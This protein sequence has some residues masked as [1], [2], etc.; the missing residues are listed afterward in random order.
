MDNVYSNHER[1]FA[2]LNNWRPIWENIARY[3]VP[4]KIG[5]TRGSI[6]AQIF[7]ELYDSTAIHANEILAASMH[8]V[9]TNQVNRWFNLKTNNEALNKNPEVMVWLEMVADV[10]FIHYY[11]SNFN[12]EINGVYVDL[13]AFGT[14]A[15]FFEE[16]QKPDGGPEFT[17]TTLP[18]GS[19]AIGEDDDGSVNVLYREFKLSTLAAL[20]K[21]G[22]QVSEKVGKAA[23]EKPEEMLIFCHA[24]FPDPGREAK[25]PYV[26]VYLEKETKKLLE[27]GGYYEFPYLVPRWAK[28][29]GEKYGRG[30]GITALPNVMTLNKVR[31]FSL[32]L[33]NK[34]V[35]PVTLLPDDGV[36]GRF[37]LKPG[38]VN[39]VRGSTEQVKFFT[40]P[41][42][43]NYETLN[44]EHLRES[45]R[46][47]FFFS[48]L[49]FQGGPQMTA[50]EVERRYELMNRVLGPTLG[51]L[52]KELLRPLISRAYNI[53]KRAGLIPP[54]P[55]QT[56]KAELEIEYDGPLVRAQKSSDIL[57]IQ[58][59]MELSGVL[60]N[61]K[62]EVLDLVDF[63]KATRHMGKITG[64]PATIFRD[65]EEVAALR[66]ERADVAAKEKTLQTAG[67]IAET[68][69][70]AAPIVKAL[71][72]E[73]VKT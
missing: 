7:K 55:V 70:K 33:L 52:E 35:D 56:D 6:P 23:K 15:L 3:I 24:V 34:I 46:D 29:S 69:K 64:V 62:P 43:I 2:E 28:L 12:S 60:A 20:K 22:D 47:I 72:E 36:L 54:F 25:K 26:S 59:F 50:T 65:D 58:R 40:P 1:Y 9:L 31:E 38:S 27:H 18:I 16:G 67:A 66:Q 19:Y 49:Q 4:N 71:K 13:G 10:I 44:V 30:P 48:Q 14:G 21:W 42:N 45:I 8:S 41:T 37:A 51:R 5:I 39:Y 17:F 11:Q 32:K 73:G 53:L 61:Y 63:D 68:A 57:T